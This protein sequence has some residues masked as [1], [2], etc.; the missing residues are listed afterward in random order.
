M[1]YNSVRNILPNTVF[2]A[3]VFACTK[4]RFKTMLG[5]YAAGV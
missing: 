1:R 4:M 5:S 3:D 2:K